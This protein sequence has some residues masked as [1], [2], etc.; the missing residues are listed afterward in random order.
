MRSVAAS[1]AAHNQIVTTRVR[2]GTIPI[3]YHAEAPA[4][5]SG[6]LRATRSAKADDAAQHVEP[7]VPA[8]SG[9]HV[10]DV[11]QPR[12]RLLEVRVAAM[13]GRPCSQLERLAEVDEQR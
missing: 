3:G 5:K 1:V 13:M 11:A 7:G 4:G 10:L 12:Q 2:T 6:R 9:G 8:R